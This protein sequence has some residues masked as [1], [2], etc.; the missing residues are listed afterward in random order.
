[1]NE[2]LRF[3]EHEPD[4]EVVYWE[5]SCLARKRL[6]LYQTNQAP[7]DVPIGGSTKAL[8]ILDLIHQSKVG[9]AISQRTNGYD[10]GQLRGM[11]NNTSEELDR[12]GVAAQIYDWLQVTVDKTQS[13]PLMAF[14]QATATLAYLT[15]L[16]VYRYD[17][18]TQRDNIDLGPTERC[19]S[20]WTQPLTNEYIWHFLESLDTTV[21]NLLYNNKEPKSKANLEA[22]HFLIAGADLFR[23]IRRFMH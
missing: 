12:E 17:D 14:N 6:S 13:G 23:K 16:K 18:A 20:Y 4:L 2:E 9:Y 22:G 21:Y 3:Q 5:A 11:L 8:R 15:S 7:L 10:L 19:L 1:M